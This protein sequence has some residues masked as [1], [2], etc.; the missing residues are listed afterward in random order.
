M[1]AP[2]LG[3]ARS[4]ASAAV[5]MAPAAGVLSGARH[6]TA[7]DCMGLRALLKPAS[8]RA[9][10]ARGRAGRDGRPAGRLSLVAAGLDS[11]VLDALRAAPARTSEL[12]PR[13]AE[14]DKELA[15]AL[16]RV[17]AVG[18]LVRHRAGRW[19]LSRRAAAGSDRRC[20]PGDVPG[21]RATYQAFA[22]YHTGRCRQLPAQ[23]AG[24]HHAVTSP[25][26]LRSSP[27]C[28]WL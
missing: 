17:L 3:P 14:S 5:D 12:T 6:A 9:L 7:W 19:R 2:A 11:G 13:T 15:E 8:S 25:S 1:T 24:G 21:V 10:V 28:R 20:R 16:L 27:G 22:D 4:L 26:T 23:L 18:A